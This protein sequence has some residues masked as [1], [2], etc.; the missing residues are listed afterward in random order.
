MNSDR[1]INSFA[2]NYTSAFILNADGTFE[3]VK[4]QSDNKYHFPEG[5]LFIDIAKQFAENAVYLPDRKKFVSECE[6]DRV[7]SR[8]VEG[9]LYVEEFRIQNPMDG[10]RIWCE[11]VVR[12]MSEQKVLLAIRPHDKEIIQ[13]H[14][15][16]R[17]YEEYAS[18]FLVDLKTDSYRFIF[19]NSDSGF[20]DVPGG[21]Y[22]DTIKEYASR[23]HP[24]FKEDWTK[25]S[26]IIFVRD[27]LSKESRIE[28]NYPLEG[29]SKR[30]RRCVLL[31]LD[32]EDGVPS[33]F[34]MTYITIDDARAREFELVAEV[35]KQKAMLEEQQ[36]QL[37][38]A[39]IEAQSAS[40]AK[41]VFMNN[42]S[43]DIRTPL[44]AIIGFTNLTLRDLDTDKDKA[45]INLEKVSTASKALLDI[46]NDI[47]EIS[48]I[49]SGKIVIEKQNCDVLYSLVNIESIMSELARSAGL[50]LQFSYGDV[51]DRYVLCD[52][53]HINRVF[54]NLISNAIKYT[55]KGGWVKVHCEQVGRRDE[56]HGLYRYTF[57]DNG[58][59]MSEEFQKILFQRF[60]REANTTVSKIQGSGLGLALCK[61]L[62]ELM[63]G[64]IECRSEKGKG[65]LFT[66]T[67]PFEI[68]EGQI[69]DIPEFTISAT[70]AQFKG[71]KVL[72]VEDNEL[73][74][75][76][77]T[78]VLEELGFVITCAEDGDIA[79]DMISNAEAGD[80]DIILM[81]IQM[82]R[83]NGYEATRR[84]RALGTPISRIPIIAMTANAFAEDRRAAI[85]SGMDGHLA[86][87]IDLHALRET[88]A[89]FV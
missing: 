14:V 21:C 6:N 62:V 8:A 38:E 65:T 86:K 61:D 37:Q 77:S 39:L 16:D 74:R 54:T 51:K 81:D 35:A 10:T 26:D 56:N 23:V 44:N 52:G 28:F 25:L 43:H 88:L 71:K 18:I 73:N 66:V 64:T 3:T 70:S 30:W 55:P 83:L 89:I 50:S 84:I 72:L 76:I 29:I 87:P 63:D 31:L 53:S 15:S 68:H 7:H 11:M 47:L 13:K 9:E 32:S 49:E 57:E 33:T 40:R 12:G 85:E 2:L 46:V 34:I 59:G 41:T 80:F 69:Y 17:L 79:V 36:K 75:E 67:L 42:M 20:K 27:L 60:S 45:R 48:R 24:D 22:S 82:P 78:A 5:T 19:R 58:I 1:I 4:Q